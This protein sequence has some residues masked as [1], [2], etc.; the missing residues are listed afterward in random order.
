MSYLSAFKTPK[1]EAIFL[2]AYNTALKFWPVPCEEIEIPTRSGTTH[3][4]VSGPTT[5]AP[6]LVLLHGY[7]ATSMMWAPNIADL[8]RDYRVY[9][10]DV[11]GQPSKSI[12]HEPMRDAT[13]YVAW[14]T[15]TL[16]ALHLDRIS[17]T[18]MSYGGWLALNYA[19]A[20]PERVQK[21]VL[22]SPGGLLPMGKQFTVRGM[23]MMLFPTRFT[24]NSF[25]GWLGIKNTPGDADARLVL[26]LMYLG[27][28]HFR[29]PQETLRVLPTVFSD[30]EL[31]HMHVPTLL[32]IGDHEVICDPVRAL[33]RARRLI[34]NFEGDLVT[35][36]SHGMCYTQH[37]IVDARVLDFLR[38]TSAT[39][40]DAPERVVA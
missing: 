36:C 35:R 23:L 30:D 12:P 40:Q 24:V 25:M 14:L 39:S 28:K 17:L 27:L 2:A 26:E 6:P 21:L 29:M 33:A 22:L 15:A 11:M 13:D 3:V 19:I 5:D 7:M 8:S 18:G 10:I 9:A 32:L 38:R 34:P 4:I 16:N 31:R 1:G 20:A 37:R